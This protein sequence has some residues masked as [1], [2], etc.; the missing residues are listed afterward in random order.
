MSI[1]EK[2]KPAFRKLE[3]GLFS[4]VEKADVGDVLSDLQKKGVALM[5]WADP[6][7]PD[8]SIPQIVLDKAIEVIKSGFPAHYIM[9]I[10]SLDLRKAIAD[11]LKRKYGITVDPARNIIINPGSDVGLMFAMTPFIGNGDEVLVH[12]PSYPSN[13]LNPELLGGVTVKVPTYEEDNYHIRIEEYEK[14]LTPKTKMV[15]ISSPNNPTGTAY[16][17]Q[18]LEKL[19][20]F[21]V[22]NDL[23]CVS[24][25]AFEDTVF[26][27]HEMINIATLPGMWERTLT[28]CSVSKGM[29]LS[30]FRVGWI[31][32]DDVIM[33]VLHGA[34]V[35]I[36][37][38]S[39]TMA[40]M[41]VLPAMENDDFIEDYMAKYDN[42]R[43]YA[44]D[45][46]NSI[47]GVSM[48]MPE[49]GFY[50]WINV[51]KL[52]DSSE[53]VRYLAQEALVNCNDGKYYG[54]QGNGHLRLI[55]GAFWNDDDCFAA[56]DRMVAALKRLAQFN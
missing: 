31:Y 11:R 6:F 52:G 15:L 34:A 37:G 35:N 19:A 22:K 3:G 29:G 38:A 20:A 7:A 26:P 12:D 41:A 16:T 36:Q 46:F 44:F 4:S 14:R 39:S 33:D 8:P 50:S 53:I 24:D 28:V 47:P 21:I 32:G 17:R 30:G 1:K 27:E 54:E 51:S 18:E 2:M 42:R 25:Q 13:F 5:S 43:K 9:P 49:A 10:G 45:A 23:I 55:H 40:Q 56:I 48:K